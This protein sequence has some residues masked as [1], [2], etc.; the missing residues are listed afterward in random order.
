[1]SIS[2]FFLCSLN[3]QNIKR[4]QGRLRDL[5]II[6]PKPLFFSLEVFGNGFKCWCIPRY[7]KY[8]FG[9]VQSC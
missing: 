5:K 9:Q 2:C 1:M 4:T 6:F 3:R 7:E 8:H